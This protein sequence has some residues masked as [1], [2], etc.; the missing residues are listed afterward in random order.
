[1]AAASLTTLTDEQ[2]QQEAITTIDIFSRFI[3]PVRVDDGDTLRAQAWVFRAGGRLV[4]TEAD[5]SLDGEVVGK[6]DATGIRVP[7]DPAEAMAAEG[8]SDE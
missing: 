7:F 2:I 4:W 6:F 8:G 5:V 1:M 3:R